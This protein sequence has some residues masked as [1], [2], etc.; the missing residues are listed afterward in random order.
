MAQGYEPAHDTPF[1]RQ[2]R[3][4]AVQLD[5]GSTRIGAHDLDIAHGD[6]AEPD[7]ECLHDRLFRGEPRG[8]ALGRITPFIC[9]VLL[10]NGEDPLFN[11]RSALQRQPEAVDIDQSLPMPIMIY[12][13]EVRQAPASSMI[14][15]ISRSDTEIVASRSSRKVGSVSV[16]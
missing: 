4:R 16:T 11:S 13:C 12:A 2:R 6:I 8:V 10:C 15:K 5:A 9:I 1:L 14:G 7:A 3:G